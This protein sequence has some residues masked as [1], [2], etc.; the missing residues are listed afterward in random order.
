LIIVFPQIICYNV[1]TP[2]NITAEEKYIMQ[3]KL[4][5]KI[6]ELRT[7]EGRTQEAL[8][9]ALGVTGQAVSRWESGVS[10]ILKIPH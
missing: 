9:S 3:L 6:K 1:I 10:Q 8:A 5:D 2:V 7:K 4:G